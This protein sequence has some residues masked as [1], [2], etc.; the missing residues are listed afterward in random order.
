MSG[1]HLRDPREA[2]LRRLIRDARAEPAPELDWMRLEERLLQQAGRR[3]TPAPLRVYPYAWGALAVAAAVVLWLVGTHSLRAVL[4]PPDTSFE[5]SGPRQALADA[6]DVGTRY[7]ASSREVTVRH[8]DRAKWT[9]A[10]GSS[11]VLLGKDEVIR[12]QLERGSV[13]SEVVPNPKPETFIVEAAGVRVAVHGTV[14][15]VALEDGRVVVD[16]RKGSV[17]VGPL[18]GAP[19]FLLEAP[20]HGNFA[21]DG[22]SG[23]IDGHSVG[24][25]DPRPVGHQK[26][27]ARSSSAAIEAPPP[28]S[29][30]VALAPVASAELPSEPSISDIE[31]GIARIVDVTGSCFARHTQSAGGVQITVHTALS[32]KVLADGAVTD[33]DFQ[34]PLSPAAEEC[35]AAGIAQVHFASS[36]QGTQ[37]TR[38]LELKK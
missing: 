5:S 4:P 27:P 13:L 26:V 12:V 33:V 2:T 3:A 35:A 29:S 16:V 19:A 28:I 1:G 37:V 20:A 38:M 7:E 6:D 14:F 17:S 22:R 32:L 8:V 11:A 36:K 10:V 34:P 23:S 21:A 15:R 18:G 31:V 30:T 9:L 25:R 24:E